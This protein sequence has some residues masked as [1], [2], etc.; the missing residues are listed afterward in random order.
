MVL[1][2]TKSGHRVGK[3]FPSQRQLTLNYTKLIRKIYNRDM[4]LTPRQ[5]QV[6]VQALPGISSDDMELLIKSTGPKLAQSLRSFISAHRA[7]TRKIKQKARRYKN[8]L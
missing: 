1:H 2:K 3:E 8:K 6:A 5:Q 4:R 7:K